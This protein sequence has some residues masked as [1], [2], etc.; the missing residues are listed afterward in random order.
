MEYHL[1]SYSSKQI[2]SRPPK[3]EIGAGLHLQEILLSMDKVNRYNDVSHPLQIVNEKKATLT[4]GYII[5]VGQMI[6][7]GF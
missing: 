5:K 4:Q 7:T 6:P 1:E 3:V 2:E